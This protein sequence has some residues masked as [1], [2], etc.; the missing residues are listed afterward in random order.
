MCCVCVSMHALHCIALVST[1]ASCFERPFI[2]FER[3]PLSLKGLESSS[4]ASN[5][6][7]EAVELGK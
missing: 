6:G 4:S 3:F 5:V 1:F 7:L 2:E